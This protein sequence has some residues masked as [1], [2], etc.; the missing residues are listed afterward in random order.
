MSVEF[1]SADKA[2][3][4][5]FGWAKKQALGYAHDGADPVGPWYEA[6]LPKREAFCMRDVSHQCGGA[7]ILGLN[8]LNLN[9]FR[10]FVSN[11]SESRD[12]CSYW[13]IN[14]HNLPAPA[15][16][17]S[18][19]DFWYNLNANFDVI[20]ACLKLFEW[21]NDRTYISA[22][23]F[24]AFF[25]N[26]FDKYVPHWQLRPSEIM[27]RPAR[28]HYDPLHDA[29]RRF[30]SSR[31]LP[32]YTENISNLSLGVDLVAVAYAA[33]KAYSRILEIKG[34]KQG[35]AG[36]SAVAEEYRSVLE[37]EWW[38]GSKRRYNTAL[39]SD[40][41]FGRGEGVPYILWFGASSD[42]E[43]I[44]ASVTDIMSYD[45]N[46]ENRSYFPTTFYR[47]GYDRLAYSQ[48]LR[49]P[50]ER[51]CAYPEVSY[52]WIEGLVRGFM[53]I[54]PLASRKEIRT[55]YHSVREDESSVKDMPVWGGTIAVTHRGLNESTLEN[56]TGHALVW[57]ASFKGAYD[58]AYVNGRKTAVATAADFL[59]KETTCV[60]VRLQNGQT[61]TV[62]CE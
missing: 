5:G 46:V 25:K 44:K 57:R 59:G 18:D 61:M 10:R 24:V 35:A 21:T 26:T 50:A 30:K 14:R 62:K 28:M 54:E 20:Q 4:S 41:K 12:W 39:S 6:A 16:Y 22:P 27:S 42:A 40:G 13:E 52:G 17:K 8:A 15:D 11:I 19:K 47:L 23:E 33:N 56:R 51:R 1:N 36:H 60:E 58:T 9:M 31:G 37:R 38:D 3:A 53:G 29:G 55:M 34:D 43:R 49:L 7:A 45:W 2:L 32:S 48:L